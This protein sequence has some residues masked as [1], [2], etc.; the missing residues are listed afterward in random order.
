MPLADCLCPIPS[1]WLDIGKTLVGV[2][3][4]AFLAFCANLYLQHLQRQRSNLAAGNMAL[5]ILS[6][7]YGDF[8]IFRAGLRRELDEMPSFAGWLQIKP[9][10][11]AL[12][13]SLRIDF[14]SL[15]FL[16]E[17][18]RHDLLGKLV[19]AE[20]KYH[21]LRNILEKNTVACEE[22]DQALAEAGMVNFS[23]ED[24]RR[25]E[26]AVNSALR[27]KCDSLNQ[28]LQQRAERD[29]LVYR[30]AGQALHSMMAKTFGTTKVMPFTAM[31]AQE[32]YV[33][34]DWKIKEINQAS[35][36]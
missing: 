13:D 36:S 16:F 5:A 18:E 15:T 6:R 29:V 32:E 10:V 14:P 33:D 9:T 4:G 3:A 20:T 30:A 27:A 19:L 7:Q 28:F 24:L 23:V 31:G 26:N 1:P 34:A 22:R 17:H 12:S 25:A 21:D 35:G 2:F 8:V 11:F